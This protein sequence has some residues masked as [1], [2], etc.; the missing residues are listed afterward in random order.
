MEARLRV[1]RKYGVKRAGF[2]GEQ[3]VE[4]E[5]FE[6][7]IETLVEEMQSAMEDEML[8]DFSD[9]EAKAFK[10]RR[11]ERPLSLFKLRRDS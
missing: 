5:F 11:Q 4:V 8:K 6:T 1:L 2:D 10:L 3:L 9:E 7:N